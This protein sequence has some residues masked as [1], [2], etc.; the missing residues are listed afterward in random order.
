MASG[1]SAAAVGTVLPKNDNEYDTNYEHPLMKPHVGQ[2]FAWADRNGDGLTQPEELSFSPM[3]G[4]GNRKPLG[5]Y[6]WGTLPGPDGTIAFLGQGQSLVKLTITG[7]TACGAPIYDLAKAQVV[8]F[9]RNVFGEGGEGMVMGGSD[10]RVYLN[11]APLMGV[12]SDGRILFTY[13]SRHVSVHGSH[14]AKASR[15]GYLIGPSSI[16]GTADLGGEIG[17]VFDLN[18]NLGENYLFT[19]DGLWIQ[20]LFKDTRGWFETPGQAVRG[21]SFDAT[22]GG[23]ESFGGNFLRAKDGK[24]YLIIGG[25]DAR[26]LEV[27]G[28]DSIK[29]LSGSINYTAEQY[30]QAQQ[31]S[32]EQAVKAAEP[33]VTTIAKAT[34]A[35]TI[36]GKADEWTELTDETKPAILIQESAQK[37]YARVAA[38]Y[39][40]DNLYLAWRVFSANDRMRNA[41]QDPNLLFKNG[42]CVDLMIGPEKSGMFSG[43]ERLLLSVM[44]GQNVAIFYEKQVPGT[45]SRVPFSSPSRTTYFDRVTRTADVKIASAPINGGYLVEAAVPWKLLRIQPQSGLKLK[46]DFGVLFGNDGGTLT[47]ARQYW[48]NKATGLVN[49]VPGEAE[50]TPNLWGALTLE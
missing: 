10:G 35:P 11:R 20:S 28:L 47:I 30:A 18:G 45:N 46:G 1:G 50:L 12:G 13:P 3:G 41:G 17:E 21:M 9:Q 33:K 14:T 31:L 16:L 48:S 6:Y 38:R 5:A 19:H 34:A 36:D 29:R 23:G 40:A 2:A 24:V 39:D 26:V 37:R 49:D 32:T 15:A 8:N 44:G 27:T 43:D 22:T 25:T 4:G 42:D 7:A